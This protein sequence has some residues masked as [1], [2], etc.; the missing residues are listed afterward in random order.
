LLN[1]KMFHK[2]TQAKEKF[3][4]ELVDMAVTMATERL[5]GMVTDEDEQNFLDKYLAAAQQ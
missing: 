2:I 5:P 1:I 3:R 4:S